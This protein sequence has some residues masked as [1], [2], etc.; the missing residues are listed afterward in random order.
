MVRVVPW[1]ARIVDVSGTKERCRVT[2]IA[3]LD[4][5]GARKWCEQLAKRNG[6]LLSDVFG[7]SRAP[8]VVRVRHEAMV[9]LK[10]TLALSLKETARLFGVDHTTVLNAERKRKGL[11]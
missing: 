2:V 10:D 7:R 5:L 11:L 9:V 3:A 6:V 8:S 1:E 4:R